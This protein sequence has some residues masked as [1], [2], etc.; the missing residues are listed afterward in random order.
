MC[1]A[2]GRGELCRFIDWSARQHGADRDVHL[3][4][5][6]D[7]VDFLADD[8]GGFMPF[9]ADDALAEAKL[10]NIIAETQEVWLALRG[11][12]ERGAA[13]TLLLGNH[14]LELSLPRARHLL[15]ATLGVG[16]VDFIYDNQAFTLGKVLVEH[17]N[18][19]DDWN[20]VPH[21][22]LR[23]VRSQ[24]SRG[25]EAA[26]DPL[27]GSRM[28][29]ELVNPLKQQLAFVD[30][31]KPED[32]ALLPFLA[33]LAPDLFGQVAT[34]LKNRIRALRVRYGADQE[35][36]DRN[37]VGADS[38]GGAA[39]VEA[40][41]TGDTEDDAYLALAQEIAAGGDASMVSS[42]GSFLSRWRAGLADA[43]RDAQLDLL[44]K[45]LLAMR[46]S[47]ARA[48]DVGVEADKYL[49]AATEAAARGYD[50]VIYGHTHLCKRVSLVG[51]A[52]VSGRKVGPSPL[53]FNSGTWADLMAV[54]DGILSA[55]VPAEARARLR[56]FADDLAENR[57]DRWRTLL[58]SFV[59]VDLDAN[60][61]VEDAA[62]QMLDPSG[63]AVAVT[64]QVVLQRLCGAR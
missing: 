2:R 53:Y 36:K 14:D 8:H 23:E 33:L 30:L 44:L 62:L 40:S 32:A 11:L 1:T 31:L 54:P 52:A 63:E 6:G 21:D 19:Y 35:P 15:S 57:V 4:I 13:L 20:A 3:V 37:F 61:G 22:D 29:V 47:Q 34:T 51:R 26:F 16:K 59:R 41:G 55:S 60:G 46:G 43:Y 5:A 10:A 39:A 58:P 24:L 28:V 27:P 9:C 7:I 56:A 50:V 45:A 42:S 17:G 49:R 25:L 64:T 48:F 18:R 38:S 12:V